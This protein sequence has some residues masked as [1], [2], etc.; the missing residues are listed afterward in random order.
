[1]PTV[2]VNPEEEEKK[3]TTLPPA[4]LPPRAGIG[5]LNLFGL[6]PTAICPRWQRSQ[7]LWH[8]FGE[9]STLELGS[10]THN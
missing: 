3:I 6:A 7:L 4:G 8:L 5:H 9:Q 1:M 10:K 2:R